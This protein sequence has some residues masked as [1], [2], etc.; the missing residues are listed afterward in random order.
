[1][2]KVAY[3]RI[4]T[5]LSI[6]LLAAFAGSLAAQDDRRVTPSG[7]SG[8]RVALVIGNDS[9]ASMPL[10]NARNDARAVRD[11]LHDEGF[12]IDYVED[13]T[14]AGFTHAMDA[15]SAKL[16]RDDVALFYYSGHGLAVD[17]VNYL[18][19][20]DFSAQSEADVPFSGYPALQV[21]RKLEERGTKL[22]IIILDACRD[23]PFRYSRS[24]GG[25]LAA[26]REGVGT[27]I[28]FAAADGQRASDNTAESNGLFTKYLLESM[29]EPGMNVRDM[30]FRV[31]ERVYE[32]SS[33]RQFPYV[34]AGAV[35][36]FFFRPAGNVAAAPV[37]SPDLHAQADLVY[38]ESIRDSKNP[39]V[40]EDYLRR[41]PDGQF[42][43]P[44]KSKLEELRAVVQPAV[45]PKNTAETAQHFRTARLD[46]APVDWTRQHAHD[47]GSK[48]AIPKGSKFK[49]AVLLVSAAGV[50]ITEANQPDIEIGC[51]SL[52]SRVVLGPGH[53]VT[54]QNR[55][56]AL[57]DLTPAISAAIR[58]NCNV[59]LGDPAP[60]D[61]PV[62]KKAK[63][64]R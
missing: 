36:Q 4:R 58:S 27:L 15:F 60:T 34:Y 9:Y 42:V 23:N 53:L 26:M 61:A 55:W 12:Q 10:H 38:W 45:M 59:Q 40:F 57:Q 31:Q 39:A 54:D 56:Y 25:G 13:A 32:A 1:M 22:N 18:L 5:T 44:A 17:G 30:F 11:T 3:L 19:P 49:D 46:G 6:A 20:V 63:S 2:K 29:R 7:S 16:Q 33:H 28:A 14:R 51:G 24:A 52:S 50:R 35:G 37:N 41:F 62:T 8:R 64:K 48:L 21:Q 43:V 47:D